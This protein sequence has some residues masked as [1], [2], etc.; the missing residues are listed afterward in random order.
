M[1]KIVVICLLIVN[2]TEA[3]ASDWFS[4]TVVLKSKIVLSGVLSVNSLHNLVLFQVGDH[5]MVYPAHKVKQVIYYD[6][7]EN[8]NRRL[9][10]VR[11]NMG[12]GIYYLLYEVV[13]AGEMPVLRRCRTGLNKV[14]DDALAYA[15]Y[16][17]AGEELVPIQKFRSRF[18]KNMVRSSQALAGF[19]ENNNLNANSSADV[20]K[21]L[22]FYN[23]LHSGAAVAFADQF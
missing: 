6:R 13:V 20:I 9:V 17:K 22:K 5:V 21:M 23:N 14:A 12:S 11:Q 15:Y 16:L 2:F 4:G 1:Q 19:I 18:Y 7:R 8:I 3:R 10:S